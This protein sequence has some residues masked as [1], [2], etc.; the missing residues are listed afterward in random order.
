MGHRRDVHSGTVCAGTAGGSCRGQEP[1]GGGPGVRAGAEDGTQ[2]AGVFGAA[3]VS[4]AEAGAAAQAG[5]VAGVHRRHS[6]RRQEPAKKQR[7][8]AKRIFE[9]LR[10]EHGYPGGY[11]IVKDYV[12]QSKLGS[13]EMFV[14]LSHAPGEAQADFGEALVVIAGVESR[15]ALSWPSTC[16]TPTTAS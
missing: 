2:D 4:A 3:R 8:T 16:P 9:R 7:H 5:A 10:D 12:R 13:R 11:T 6:G 1:A 15:G 14:P